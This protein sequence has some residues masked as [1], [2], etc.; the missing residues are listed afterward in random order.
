MDMDW[1]VLITT[2]GAIF[3]AEFGDKTQLAAIF[4]A[5][6]TEKPLAV[7]IGAALALAA[8]TLIGVTLGAEIAQ[9]VPVKYI[10]S[11]AAIAFIGIGV[12]I[13]LGKL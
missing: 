7:F 3:A 11:G 10:R 5:S 4:L 12:L 8:V 2:F 9:A 13:L 6:Q 1:K